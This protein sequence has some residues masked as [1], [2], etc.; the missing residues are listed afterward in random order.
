MIYHAIKF[1]SLLQSFAEFLWEFE[2]KALSSQIHV[3]E[4][5]YRGICYE[6]EYLG[7]TL[8]I[9]PLEPTTKVLGRPLKKGSSLYLPCI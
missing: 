7:A 5:K 4:I 8:A 3:G 1:H 2:Q 6:P 9:Q